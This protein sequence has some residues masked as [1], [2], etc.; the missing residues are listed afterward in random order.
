M[1]TRRSKLLI[2]V[3]GY[4]VFFVS[5]AALIAFSVYV[6]IAA[7]RQYGDNKGIIFALMLVTVLFLALVCTVIDGIRRKI[8]VD[9]PVE[10]ISDATARIAAGDFSV[11]IQTS[12]PYG[13]YDEFDC[14]ADNINTMAAELSKTKVLH[15]DFVSNVSHELKTPLAIIQNYSQAIKGDNLDD[16]TRK[17][18]AD[19]LVSTSKRLTALVTNIL[20]LNRLEN[21]Q[22]RTE[23]K[24]IRLNEMLAQSVLAFE[25]SIEAKGLE[26][27]CDLDEITIFSDP[28]YLEIVW[29]NLI[30]NAIKFTEPN[31]KIFISLKEEGGAAVVK[32]SDAG[33]GISAETG[34]HIFDKFYQGD[35]SHAQEGN[36]LG[37]ALVKKVIDVLGGEISVESQLGKGST[38][39]VRLRGNVA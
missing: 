19:V 31:G 13:R 32:V 35:T 30:S 3:T 18:Y 6:Y 12:H 16:E 7:E 2:L 10:N 25:D 29:S 27:E 4:A 1:K 11:R 34:R 14:I 15:T 28:D 5:I 36:G 38:F 24:S 20:K 33:C 17:R 22:I 8:T 9:R 37:L 26:L 21:Q 39:I 23:P